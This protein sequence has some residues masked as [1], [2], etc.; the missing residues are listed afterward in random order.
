[1]LS[2]IDGE[3]TDTT[4]LAETTVA[5]NSS[6]V[7]ES[8]VAVTDKDGGENGE[9]GFKSEYIIMAACAVVILASAFICIMMLKKKPAVPTSTEDKTVGETEN[10]SEQNVEKSDDNADKTNE[11][12]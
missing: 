6:A 10:I 3:T 12:D 8:N 4:A 1:M 11:N 5:D 9:S 7:E 2:E